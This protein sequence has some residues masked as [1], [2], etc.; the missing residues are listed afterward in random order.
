MKSRM[1]R[2]ALTMASV[3]MGGYL[4]ATGGCLS[5]LGE[6]ALTTLDFCFVIDC[7][8]G[9]SGLL[10]PCLSRQN[11]LFNEDVLFLDCPNQAGP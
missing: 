6:Q 3:A 5:Y 8:D 10:Q 9:L 7:T 11:D 4:T 2:F 1:R